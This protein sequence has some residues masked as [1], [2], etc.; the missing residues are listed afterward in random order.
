[1]RGVTVG[2]CVV[3]AVCGGLVYAGGKKG[4]EGEEGEGVR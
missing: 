2:C 3:N 1:M 4:E